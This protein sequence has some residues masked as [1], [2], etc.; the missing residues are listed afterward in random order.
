MKE[1]VAVSGTSTSDRAA[2]AFVQVMK[3]AG[4]H[5]GLNDRLSL[6][7]CSQVQERSG[8]V[9]DYLTMK[10]NPEAKVGL[11]FNPTLEQ[12]VTSEQLRGYLAKPTLS[13]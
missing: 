5:P 10:Q 3:G 9:I 8:E 13:R 1:P 7:A 6:L 12:L 11:G 2:Q 4:P